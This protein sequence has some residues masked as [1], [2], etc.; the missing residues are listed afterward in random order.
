MLNA[1]K[2]ENN[3]AY[4]ENGAVTNR[5]SLS[6]C[7]DFFATVGALRWASDAEI[8]TRFIRAFGED[9]DV[10]LKILF[11]GRDVREGLGER[12]TFRVILKYLGNNHPSTIKKNI[13]YIAEYGRFDDLLCLLDTECRDEVIAYIKRQLEADMKNLAKGESISL[14]AKWMPS[15]NASNRETVRLANILAKGLNLKPGQ[16]RKMLSKLRQSLD[17]IENRLRENDYTFNYSKQPSKAMLK[18]KAAFWRNDGERYNA[19]LESVS[20]GEAKLNAS[21]IMP[22]ELVDPYLGQYW[23]DNGTSMR[24]ITE[25]ES[26]TL[27]AIWDAMPDFTNRENALVIVDT[28]GSMYCC[29]NPKPASVALS[30]GIYLAERNQGLFHDYFIE[31]SREP[32]LIELKG[33]TFTDKLRYITTFNEVA[34]TNIEAVFK[35]ILDAAVKNNIPQ[36]EL[37]QTL[38][39]VSDM[40]FNR[41]VRN[42]DISNFENAKQMFAEHGYKLPKVVFWN[43]AARGGNMPVTKNEAGVALV[44]GCTPNL[45]SRV[46]A[47]DMNPYDFMM[48]VVGSERYAKIAA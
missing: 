30:L 41:C 33:E 28:S 36:E 4:T 32:R 25:E 11:F 12:R 29:E 20:R 14:L 5:S 34:D 17:L 13:E 2:R 7:V 38:Y 23:Y 40:Q 15:I 6:D 46:L 18:Y 24:D 48:E 16:Y 19:Y 10:G 31:F 8:V 3:V 1:L 21:T 9:K 44:S 26:L 35:L 42:A 45:F 27:N 39:I 22:Y 47:D 37:P 43:V